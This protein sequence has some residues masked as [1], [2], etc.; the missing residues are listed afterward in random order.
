MNIK[1]LLL[2]AV[3][4]LILSCDNDNDGDAPLGSYD[5]GLL[6][7]NEGNAV[8]GSIT[9][10]S[11]DMQTIQHDIFE[12]V[13]PAQDMGGYVQS[14]FFDD[15]RA[16]L[17]SNFA[18]KI[19]VV[20]RYTFEYIS[21]IS[22]G[23]DHPRY[24]TVLNGKA[25]V[26]NSAG[27]E[28]GADDF[29]TVINLQDLSVGT[30]IMINDYAERITNDGSQV[31]VANGSFGA[32]DSIT[33]INPASQSVFDEIIV[34]TAPNSMEVK[35]GKLYVLTSGFG[36]DS[37][38]V[39]IDLSEGYPMQEISFPASMQNASNI[40]IEGSNAYFN[41]GSKVYKVAADAD[42][43]TDSPLFDTQSSSDYIGYGFAVNGNRIYIAEATEDFISDGKVYVYSTNGQPIEQIPAGV[44][45]NGIYFNE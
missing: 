4:G 14:M 5:N 45:P 17:I 8:S 28:S 13:N 36:V 33:V 22:T 37:K 18:N 23:F 26:T 41:V 42:T 21:T 27:W 6:I 9:Y 2:I 10:A 11:D 43:I 35:D 39:R 3:S 34:G 15:D 20:N 29:V 44:G 7:L 24:G 1:N 32:G 31:Y 40:D 16:F 19:T 12:V 25:Y 38:L 30:P